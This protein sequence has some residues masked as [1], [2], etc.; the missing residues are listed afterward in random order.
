MEM[1]AEGPSITAGLAGGETEAG[2]CPQ[3]PYKLSPPADPPVCPQLRRSRLTPLGPTPD[4]NAKR[5]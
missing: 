1:P 4:R 2:T 5:S 3:P